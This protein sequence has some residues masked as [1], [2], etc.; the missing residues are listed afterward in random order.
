MNVEALNNWHVVERN[1]Y[2]IGVVIV[3]YTQSTDSTR[4]NNDK[5]TFYQNT[6]KFFFT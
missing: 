2:Y 1:K 4:Y 6:V 3:F 5:R